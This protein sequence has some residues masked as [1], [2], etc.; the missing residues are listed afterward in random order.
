[1]RMGGVIACS[2]NS[3]PAPIYRTVT[4]NSDGGTAVQS[5][6][7]LN[8]Q[9]ADKP[10][11][12]TKTGYTFNGW[13]KGSKTSAYDFDT[14]VNED[15][16]LTAHWTANTYTVTF[17]TGTGASDPDPATATVTFGQK[18]AD[19]ASVP[20]KLGFNFG[21]YYT[22]QLA[23]GT[24]FI[25][26]DGKGCAAWNIASNTTLYAAFGVAII[27]NTN[28]GAFNIDVENSN[29]DIYI[30]GK[31]LTS[32]AALDGTAK[33][34]TFNGWSRTASGPVIT[35]PAISTTE[36]TPQTFCALWT[37]I[38]YSITYEAGGFENPNSGTTSYTVEDA[39][40]NLSDARNGFEFDGW[41]DAATGG[42]KVESIPQGSTGNKTLYAR[43]TS[44]LGTKASPDTLGDIVFNN[45]RAI[46]Y[47]EGLILHADAKAAAIAVCFN[48]DGRSFGL[49]QTQDLNFVKDTTCA[50]WNAT[51]AN[52]FNDG[53]GNTSK[54]TALTDYTQENYPVIWWVD[55]Y[56]AVATNLGAYSSDWYLPAKNE[57]VTELGTESILNT[58]NASIA[59]IG[60]G[61]DPL[62]KV[63]QN[64][65]PYYVSSTVKQTG[66]I[67]VIYSS[68]GS[69]MHTLAEGNT[70]YIRAI[71]KFP[72]E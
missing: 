1:M 34:Y 60:D 43:W 29:P 68:Y 50:G 6:S 23:E 38:E 69:N 8:G 12:P 62:V 26:K 56:S 72:S 24:K 63:V 22:E 45:G 58:L 7:V 35:E 28:H 39:A 18:L 70:K 67:Y 55:H 17:V 9:K 15:I 52:N 42:N 13:F 27:Y 10:D 5:Q 14:A 20:T 47:T 11:D 51:T 57:I 64:N 37:P 25:D 49:K 41:Y 30:V 3:D 71:H 33:G 21:G 32:L 53:S 40:I 19:I 31:G 4:F 59:K 36:D 44:A 16:T 2:N 54:I 48:A 65:A 61:A 46:D 66:Q